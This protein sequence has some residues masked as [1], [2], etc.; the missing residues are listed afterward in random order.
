MNKKKMQT[1]NDV[2]PNTHIIY[3]S[4]LIDIIINNNR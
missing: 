1:Q 4:L 3:I 2:N